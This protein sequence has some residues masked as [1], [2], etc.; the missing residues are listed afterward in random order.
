MVT[1]RRNESEMSDSREVKK[2]AALIEE[3]ENNSCAGCSNKRSGLVD[4]Q[5]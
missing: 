4:G 1:A 3:V 2:R 5:S